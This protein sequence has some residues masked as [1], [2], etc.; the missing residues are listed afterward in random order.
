[1]PFEV[2]GEKAQTTL[3]KVRLTEK[4]K[5]LIRDDAELAGFTMSEL[6][7]RRT[8]GRAVL[9]SADL[10]MV[11]ELRRIGGL[12]KQVHLQSRGAYSETTA[13]CLAVLRSYIEKLSTGHS[14]RHTPRAAGR[15]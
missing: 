10:T 4:E 9:A 1:M 14:E 11:R 5:Q 6:I 15:R 12:L 7:R 13:D 8:F 2:R 3:V